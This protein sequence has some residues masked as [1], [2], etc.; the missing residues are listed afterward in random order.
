MDAIAAIQLAISPPAGQKPVQQ[1]LDEPP[2]TITVYPLFV[3]AEVTTDVKTKRTFGTASNELDHQIDMALALAPADG[4]YAIRMRRPW[5]SVVLDAFR[6]NPSLN[7]TCD[8][9]YVE[10]VDHSAAHFGGIDYPG[11]TF[12]LHVIAST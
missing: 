2:Y 4:I 1:A 6:Q 11:L 3:N 8:G 10:R 5:V 12:R 7:S 9:A